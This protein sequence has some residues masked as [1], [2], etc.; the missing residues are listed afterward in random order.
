MPSA[1]L[2][3]LIIKQNDLG[4]VKYLIIKENIIN[5]FKEK[6]FHN[7]IDSKYE[8]LKIKSIIDRATKPFMLPTREEINASRQSIIDE[9]VLISQQFDEIFNQLFEKVE[10]CIVPNDIKY[11]ELCIYFDEKM[12]DNNNSRVKKISMKSIKKIL[13]ENSNNN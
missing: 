5:S 2:L 1:Y 8:E 3:G 12:N 10:L 7:W 6:Y 4:G 9:V 13:R 11:K